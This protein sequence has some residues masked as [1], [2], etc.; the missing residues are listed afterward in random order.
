MSATI[1]RN[2]VT[3]NK[4]GSSEGIRLPKAF[5]RQ[6]GISPGDQVSVR[7]KGDAILIEKLPTGATLQERMKGWDGSRF[8][9]AELD[10][11]KPV[12]GELW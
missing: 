3:V 1:E 8:K 12:G 6:L 10:W 2:V 7:I 9:S 5:C 11:G 4:W